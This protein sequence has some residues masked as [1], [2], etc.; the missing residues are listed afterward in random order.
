M[1]MP[2]AIQN[3]LRQ[4][5][6][7]LSIHSQDN[8]FYTSTTLRIISLAERI[9]N[10]I[11]KKTLNQRKLQINTLNFDIRLFLITINNYNIHCSASE[12]TKIRRPTRG[13][14]VRRPVSPRRL[15]WKKWSQVSAAIASYCGWR[16]PYEKW[17]QVATAIVSVCVKERGGAC[18]GRSGHKWQQ[19]SSQ[20]A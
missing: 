15:I 17:S 3:T 11:L 12:D 6:R 20:S 2:C 13:G 8:E 9:R 16:L 1:T 18:H 4:I 5:T 14:V 10:G 7:K 19:Q